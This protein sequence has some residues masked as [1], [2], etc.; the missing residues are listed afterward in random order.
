MALFEWNEQI[1]THIAKIDDQHKELIGYIN[2]L[3]DSMRAGKS[4]DVIEKILNGLFEYTKYH[5]TFEEEIM[6]KYEYEHLEEQRKAHKIYVQ[7][8]GELM[9][10]YKKSSIGIGVDVLTFL[11]DWIKNH[12]LSDDMQYVPLLKDKAI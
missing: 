10:K 11:M 8:I 5:F 4:K 2:E 9:E 1:Q 7:K 6:E 3:H 12:I